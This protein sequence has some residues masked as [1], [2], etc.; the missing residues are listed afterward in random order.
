MANYN[1]DRADIEAL[2]TLLTELSARHIRALVVNLPVTQKYIDLADDGSADYAEY[3]RQVETTTRTHGAQW[4][5]TMQVAWPDIDFRD[6]NHLNDTG[7]AALQ[8]II[9]KAL[10]GLA[11][12]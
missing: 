8:P 1:V 7:T 3:T 6:L 12:R 11:P 5:D 10:N 2:A 4:L 9:V